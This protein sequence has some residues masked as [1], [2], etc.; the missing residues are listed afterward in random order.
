MKAVV[1][2]KYGEA[3]V[4]EVR[5]FPDLKPGPG[6]LRIAVK[7]AGL[8]F[9]EVSARQGLYPDAPK[10]PCVVGYEVAGVVDALG[11]GAQGFKPGDRVWA[12]TKFNG[13][14][15]QVCVPIALV[16]RMP[17]A[18]SFEQ[19]A[20]MP[21]VY[22]T[23]L[24]LVSHYGR[25]REGERVLIHMAAGGVGLA[26]LQLCRRVPGVTIFGTASA[27]KHAYLKEQGLHHPIDYRSLDFEQE[28]MKLSGGKGVHLV[29]DPM[30]GGNWRKNYRLLAPLGRLML[31]GLA[32]ATRPGSRS[33]LLALSQII[34][35]PRWS[36]LALMNENRAVMG[37]NLGHLF[38]EA[39]TIKSGLDELE[40]LCAE[41]AIR[42]TVDQV[43]PF[44]KAADA[45]RRIEGRANIGKVV[46]VPDA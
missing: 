32:N 25:L 5:D 16:R 9:A 2:P 3:S 10:P 12:M 4:L 24:L 44:S 26:A 33:L 30:G 21:V 15:E 35:A 34:Q 45:H 6:E 31:F 46:L 14:A 13:H 28:V 27:S 19:A 42:P 20:A 1:I 38:G 8:N 23:A 29:L 18:M 17:E 11:P 43:F 37:L 40:R 39:E 41:G 7:A 22:S 36:P